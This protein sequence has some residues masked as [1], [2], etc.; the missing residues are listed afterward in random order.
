M[1]RI[2]VVEKSYKELEA[3]QDAQE[4]QG[5]KGTVEWLNIP[6]E[7]TKEMTIYSKEMTISHLSIVNLL[8]G[9]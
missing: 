9:G 2:N 6:F 3:A 5:R 4:Q 8:T 7:H 1:Q